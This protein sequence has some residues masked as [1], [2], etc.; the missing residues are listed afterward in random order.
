VGRVG[1]G[2][3]SGQ[4]RRSGRIVARPMAVRLWEALQAERVRL[5]EQGYTGTLRVEF[6]MLNGTEMRLRLC[7]V[8]VT[9]EKSIV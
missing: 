5:Q 4:D 9:E 6:D 2:S 1:S 8:A 7:K 3:V